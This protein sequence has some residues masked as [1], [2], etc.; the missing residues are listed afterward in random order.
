LSHARHGGQFP[1]IVFMILHQHEHLKS[2]Q[3]SLGFLQRQVGPTIVQA[4]S[5]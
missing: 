1:V 4:Y 3:K 5:L 2:V